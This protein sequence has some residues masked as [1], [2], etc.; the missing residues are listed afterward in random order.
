MSLRETRTTANQETVGF[1]LISVF[2]YSRREIWSI[3]LPGILFRSE[4]REKLGAKK[5][6]LIEIWTSGEG[7]L[8]HC[9]WNDGSERRSSGLTGGLFLTN[10]RRA[11]EMHGRICDIRG[12]TYRWKTFPITIVHSCA[13]DLYREPDLFIF[14]P[15]RFNLS[16]FACIRP[17]VRL[18]FHFSRSL[19]PFYTPISLIT[20]DFNVIEVLLMLLP[21]VS[22]HKVFQMS[23]F[24]SGRGDSLERIF[25]SAK[26]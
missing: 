6:S 2:A 26:I 17:F 14:P 4:R 5:R 21:V 7:Y 9:P 8:C 20:I 23:C 19:A 18:F 12:V 13:R 10:R 16:S 3:L 24:L 1:L 25:P 11:P 22:I 15:K